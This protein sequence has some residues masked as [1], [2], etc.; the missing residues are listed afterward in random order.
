MAK[1]KQMIVTEKQHG[2]LTRMDKELGPALNREGFELPLVIQ[3][4]LE[5]TEPTAEPEEKKPELDPRLIR[6]IDGGLEFY[7]R[8]VQMSINSRYVIVCPYID[9]FGPGPMVV[10][11]R[12][13][14]R[15][16]MEMTN[17]GPKPKIIKGKFSKKGAKFWARLV[18]TERPLYKF[19]K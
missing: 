4:P 18:D 6:E 3:K 19:V 13:R 17:E 15:T 14:E 11:K 7:V 5:V 9:G 12:G 16:V 10:P 2:V 8:I 1:K